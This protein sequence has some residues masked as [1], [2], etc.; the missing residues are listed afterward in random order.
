MQDE[1]GA[2][3]ATDDALGGAVSQRVLRTGAIPSGDDN[4]VHFQ[5]F[6][7]LGNFIESNAA[8][9]QGI[10]LA[11]RIELPPF[12]GVEMFLAPLY[13]ARIGSLA[14][15]RTVPKVRGGS[16]RFDHVQQHQ[17]SAELP[18]ETLG[19]AHRDLRWRGKISWQKDLVDREGG[20]WGLGRRGTMPSQRARACPGPQRFAV[21]PRFHWRMLFWFSSVISP[22]PLMGTTHRLSFIGCFLTDPETVGNQWRTHLKLGRTGGIAP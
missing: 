14:N 16:D 8:A 20:E 19:V 1:N 17:A 21:V 12:N 2:C 7:D 15:H 10:A 13:R 6:R 9:D 11:F 3:R 22:H 18:G 5:F 4:Q